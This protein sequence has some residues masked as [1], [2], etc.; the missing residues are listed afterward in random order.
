MCGIAGFVSRRPVSS[1]ERLL[2]SQMNAALVHR[3]PDGAGEYNAENVALAMRR[4]S[5]IDLSGGWQPLYNEDRSLA[6]ITN[7]EIYNFVELRRDLERRGHHFATGSDCETI[8]HLYEDHGADCVQHLRG[9]FA[10]ALW[11]SRSQ[12]LLLGRDRMGEKPLYLWE[13]GE[14]VFFASELR[15]L[16]RALP[17]KPEL[18]PVSIDLYFHYGYVPE[19]RTPLAGIR[20]LPAG[21]TLSVE[22]QPWHIDQR[23]YWDMANAAPLKGDPV[24]AI[25]A[26][27]DTISS[28]IIRSDVPVGV[29][30]SG[31]VDSG[32]LA[33]LAAQKYSGTMH[34]FSIG[35]PGRPQND[36]RAD[37]KRLADHLGLPFHEV[38]LATADLVRFFPDLVY[39]TD[40]P[41][42]DIAGYGYYT[43][44][45]LAREHGVPVLLQGQGGDELFWGYEWVRLAAVD[46][47]A[48]QRVVEGSWRDRWRLST[49]YL[50]PPYPHSMSPRQWKHWAGRMVHGHNPGAERW[51][52][53]ANGNPDSAVFIDSISYFQ[54]IQRSA[55]ELYA[56]S[57]LE[58]LPARNA[59]SPFTFPHPWH[60]VP[61]MLTRLISQTYLLENGIAQGDRLSMASS[62]EL[63]LPLVDYR[64]AEIVI[65]HRKTASD[66]TLPRKTW[67]QNALKGVL[68]DWVMN[69][70]KRGFTPPA[71]WF[72]SLF[73]TYG[74]HIPDGFL[75]QAGIAN[76]STLARWFSPEGRVG[77]DPFFLFKTLCLELWCRAVLAGERM[78]AAT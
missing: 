48:K 30:L 31:G 39:R 77:K 46:S 66:H 56:A 15:A 40:D 33:A 36:E 25:R 67:L 10:F 22:V 35:Y 78:S 21:H 49:S 28:I 9:M 37:A 19:P 4:L 5:I 75:V 38:E 13:N 14:G 69:R 71:E 16:L 2:V 29:A 42:A 23:Q 12:R 51:R 27:L 72:T 61:V 58:R 45:R 55:Q 62:V 32:A 6:L 70:P 8:L 11:D 73:D 26:E 65:G 41:I 60:D 59:Y 34:A 52:R 44:S 53:I 43:V 63:R 47:L 1:A 68:P 3:G 7:G 17:H 24:E 54:D 18:D 50:V 20:K 57:I 74:Q 64:L 76:S